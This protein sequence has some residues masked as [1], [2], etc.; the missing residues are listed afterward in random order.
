MKRCIASADDEEECAVATDGMEHI[1]LLAVDVDTGKTL[2]CVEARGMQGYLRP[3]PIPVLEP[4]D[5][6]VRALQQY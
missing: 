6:Q 1:V 3:R 5:N 4:D 2:G